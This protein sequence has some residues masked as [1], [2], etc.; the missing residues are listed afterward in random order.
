MI[1]PQ[2]DSTF[3]IDTPRTYAASQ[4]A[5]GRPLCSNE[6]FQTQWDLMGACSAFLV[7]PDVVATAGHC[8]PTSESCS[9][10]TFAFGVGYNHE[11]DDPRVLQQDQIFHCKKIIATGPEDGADFALIQLDRP[12]ININ[13]LKIQSFE[14]SINSDKL[15]IIGYP[16]ALP[17]KI[18]EGG[19]HLAKNGASWFSANLDSFSGSSGSPV[20]NASSGVVE[21]ILSSGE[22]DFVQNGSCW[23]TKSCKDDGSDCEGEEVTKINEILPFVR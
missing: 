1:K 18:A 19:K 23:S 8:F 2:A 21:G 7:S 11:H 17:L 16:S 15:T 10:S 6:K 3:I 5:S 12:A 20:I 9:F 14:Q 4:Q 22:E 13:P